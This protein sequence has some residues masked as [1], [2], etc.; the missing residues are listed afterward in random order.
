MSNYSQFSY[1]SYGRNTKIVETVSGS[2]TDTR[3]AVWCIDDKRLTK[4]CEERDAS[5]TLVK[6]FFSFGQMNSSS[7]LFTALDH[8]E[9][10]REMTDNS[11]VLQAQYKP[12][13]FGRIEK[14]LESTASDF[15]Y[16]GY[17]QHGRSGLDLALLRQ[18]SPFQARWISRDPIGELEGANLF[19]YVS[20]HPT[21][22]TD[23]TGLGDF[24]K[25]CNADDNL[26]VPDNVPTRFVLCQ[27][28]CTCESQTARYKCE[29]W[30]MYG[31]KF[32]IIYAGGVY[33]A[34][35]TRCLIF[36]P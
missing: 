28:K 16:A 13:P 36:G 24:C 9:S 32:C 31:K 7:K 33:G 3:Q 22:L 10:V 25:P 14:I 18:Y 35:M 17:Y 34:C 1:D 15:Q 26:P 29:E 19:C 8:L 4:P 12:D 5:G 30:L 21:M 27:L 6:K 2:V 11:G 20:N 23:P